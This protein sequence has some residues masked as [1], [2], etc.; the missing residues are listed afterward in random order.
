VEPSGYALYLLPIGLTAVCLILAV[1]FSPRKTDIVDG[2]LLIQS[3]F[4]TYRYPLKRV[5]GAE[6]VDP[7]SLAWRSTVRVCGVGWP[8]K[9]YGYFWNRKVGSFLAL[10]DKPSPLFLLKLDGNKNL[11]VST[12]KVVEELGSRLT[13]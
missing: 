8:M 6:K 11:L 9:S 2:E 7:Q 10:A 12:N 1:G 13:A 3:W 5:I 4:R